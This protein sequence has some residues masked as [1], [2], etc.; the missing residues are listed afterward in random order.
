MKKSKIKFVFF[1]LFLFFS[2]VVFSQDYTIE[3]TN[4]GGKVYDENKKFI[5]F[6][7]SKSYV[8]VDDTVF[9]KKNIWKVIE[10]EN[11]K[12]LLY[13]KKEYSFSFRG[14]NTSIVNFSAKKKG[15]VIIFYTPERSEPQVHWWYAWGI[16]VAN[17]IAMLIILY[18]AYRQ[19]EQENLRKF[20]FLGAVVLMFVNI[21]TTQSIFQYIKIPDDIVQQLPA[22][23]AIIL[24]LVSFVLWIVYEL[25]IRRLLLTSSESE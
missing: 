11:E 10:K 23:D 6:V 18:I 17:I 20:F 19:Q 12:V 7:H 4:N 1:C 15:S 22:F 8:N 14:L 9:V 2:F 13:T 3:N 5:A 16:F 21:I 25:F 24:F